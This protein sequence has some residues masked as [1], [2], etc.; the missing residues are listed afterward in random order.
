M[1]EMGE[2]DV[3]IVG[4]GGGFIEELWVFNEEMVVRVI[5]KSE[6]FIILVVGYEMDFI[7]VDFVVDLCVLILIVVV[8]L[9]VFNIIEL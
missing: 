7:I 6:I 9:V 3:L 4:C 2:I 5:F 1:N 8:E